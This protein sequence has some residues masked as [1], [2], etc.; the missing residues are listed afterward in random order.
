MTILPKNLFKVS[1]LNQKFITSLKVDP[2]KLFS[3]EKTT[4]RK[5]HI[6]YTYVWELPLPP[7]KLKIDRKLYRY[8]QT[9]EWA[10]SLKNRADFDPHLLAQKPKKLQQ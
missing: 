5:W 10:A 6:S 2:K 3:S 9:A 4:L 1:N 7:P 8:D